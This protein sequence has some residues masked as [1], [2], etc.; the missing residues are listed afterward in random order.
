MDE[1][2][3]IPPHARQVIYARNQNTGYKIGFAPLHDLGK[4][5]LFG[6]FVAENKDGKAYA[7]C[8]NR[9]DEPVVLSLP[10]VELEPCEIFRFEATELDRVYVLRV[11]TDKDS[12]STARIF[13]ELDS[14]TLKG[15]NDEEIE[16]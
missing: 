6:N 10:L 8:Y 1:Q 2:F 15:L 13:R 11:F 7:L 9:G 14:D 4:G 16:H 12:D 3:L 5:L